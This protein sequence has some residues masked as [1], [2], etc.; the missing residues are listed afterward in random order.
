M[1]L[2]AASL[3]QAINA[4][5]NCT[6]AQ[7]NKCFC[8]NITEQ[9]IKCNCMQHYWPRQWMQRWVAF[10]EDHKCHCMQH[11]WWRR[12][13]QLQMVELPME[14]NATA[15]TLLTKATNAIACSI[16]DQGK[17]NYAA[18]ATKAVNATV[19]NITGQG[20]KCNCMQ[21]YWSS[22]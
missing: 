16:P 12:W 1:Q 15:T 4:A 3:T 8:A 14:I 11:Y 2:H 13:M 22:P 18:W 6:T 19:F 10:E 9:C 17:C 7:G 20:N 21:Y 5:A